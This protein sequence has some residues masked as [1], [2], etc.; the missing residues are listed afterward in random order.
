MFLED[1]G[2]FVYELCREPGFWFRFFKFIQKFN[3]FNHNMSQ[4][5]QK[6]CQRVTFTVFFSQKWTVSNIMLN[7]MF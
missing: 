3:G 7:V 4:V 2:A 6:I 5:R 1:Y